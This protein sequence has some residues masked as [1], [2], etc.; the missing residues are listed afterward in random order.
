MEP[1]TFGLERMLAIFHAIFE[2]LLEFKFCVYM[3]INYLNFV[4]QRII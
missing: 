3:F 4:K 1:K 2:G